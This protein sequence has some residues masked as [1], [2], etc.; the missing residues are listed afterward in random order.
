MGPDSIG[1]GRYQPQISGGGRSPLGLGL[2]WNLEEAAD[3]GVEATKRGKLLD[4]KLA[5]M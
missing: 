3:D 1:E 4:E 5:A 2:G